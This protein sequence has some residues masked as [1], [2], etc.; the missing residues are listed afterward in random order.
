MRWKWGRNSEKGGQGIAQHELP[1]ANCGQAQPALPKA[2]RPNYA[3]I[4]H[5]DGR[6][7]N[8]TW[9]GHSTFL[10][11]MGGVNL[12]TDPHWSEYCAPLPLARYRRRTGPGLSLRE[13]PRIDAVLLSHNHY[14]HLDRATLE[15]LGRG[16]RIFCPTGMR[17]LLRGWGFLSVS[18]HSWGETVS[19]EGVR[20]TALPAQHGSARTALDRNRSLWCGWMME[21]EACRVM[22]LGDTGYAPFFREFR[23]AFGAV[24]AALIPIGA[25]RPGWFMKP[26][27]LNPW[28]AVQVHLELQARFSVAMHWGTFDL[29][30]EPLAEPPALLHQAREAAGVEPDRFQVVGQGSTLVIPERNCG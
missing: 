20:L 19:L 17:A 15:S 13:L 25:Y 14:D 6:S 4:R 1:P 9:I 16:S 27:H 18:E 12:L 10:I 26:V 8:L 3:A 11:Q 7:V 5:P 30:D 23:T 2:M 28:E 29:A 22:F 21:S 24:D